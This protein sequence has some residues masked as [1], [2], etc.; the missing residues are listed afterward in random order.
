MSARTSWMGDAIR[1]AIAGG[2]AVWLMDL[3]TTGVYEGQSETA[4]AREAEARPN[5]KGSVENLVDLL[6][7]R[8]N[9]DLDAATRARLVPVVHY[10]LGIVPGA[11]YGAAR[12]RVPLVGAGRGLLYGIV[13][14]AAN[15]EWLNTA[16]G[17]AGPPEAYPPE[18]HLRGLIGH[19][20]LGAATDTGIDVLGG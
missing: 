4:K 20:A 6:A 12:G 3:V 7:G 15:D 8:L 9:L 16:L 10:G 14:F 18:S 13:L 11:L 5:G 2:I 19:L 1:G 17:L